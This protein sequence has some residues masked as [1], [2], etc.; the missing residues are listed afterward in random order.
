VTTDL[1]PAHAGG[2]R[3]NARYT[4]LA[5][6][7]PLPADMVRAVP[8]IRRDPLAYLRGVTARYGDLVAF[9]MPRTPVL[10]VD[11]PA[12]AARVLRDN[13][14]AWGKATVQYRALSAV[15]G[16]GLLTADGDAWRHH[17]RIAQPAFRHGALDGVATQ[18]VAA[19]E[20]LRATWDA[21]GPD[22]PVDADAATMRA[23]LAVVG[24]TLFAADLA[25]V[26]DRVVGAVD[27]ALHAVVHRSASP[28]ALG[29][30]GRLPTPSLRRLRRAVATLDDVAAD[31]VARR[32]AAPDL[33]AGD[34]VLALLLRAAE[35]GALT[36]REV[37]DELVTLVVAG[38]ETVASSLTWTLH[39]LA[40]HPS[41][42][43]DL[44]AELD[45]VLG[46]RAPAWADVPALRR[47]RA[48][49]D[50]ALRLFPPAWVITRRALADDVV[51][52]VEVPAGTLAILSPWLLHRRPARWPDP[53]RFDPARFLGGANGRAGPAGPAAVDAG[54]LPFGAGPRL[55]IGRDLALVETVLVVAALLRD[56]EVV[57]PPGA[58]EPRVDALVT[59]RPRGGLPLL[60]RRR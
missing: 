45:A 40:G 56:R 55:C 6:D 23:M 50:E 8:A 39:L 60:L 19:A 36:G 31:V 52:G 33:A 25:P 16:A 44:H 43:R 35:A 11:D 57:R 2:R 7:G 1:A 46:G 28:L 13:H 51:A 49:V 47:T 34:D 54:Y 41:V 21:A 4:P 20:D 3:R 10:L 37:R 9:P 32:R 24:R 17:R 38:H 48:V 27:A 18:A 58:P 30:L 5:V 59:L 53:D 29:P 42:Q 22:T 15:T 12:G 26:A 14:R